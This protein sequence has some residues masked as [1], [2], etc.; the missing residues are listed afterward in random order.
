MIVVGRVDAVPVSGK[1]SKDRGSARRAVRDVDDNTQSVLQDKPFGVVATSGAL[2][3]YLAWEQ[4][5]CNEGSWCAHYSA[6]SVLAWS[7]WS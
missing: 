6:T 7:A 1:I 5:P 4:L 2:R 3:I